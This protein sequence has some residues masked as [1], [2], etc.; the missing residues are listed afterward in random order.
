VLDGEEYKGNE[1][2]EDYIA[3]SHEEEETPNEEN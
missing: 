2:I 1:F 3:T